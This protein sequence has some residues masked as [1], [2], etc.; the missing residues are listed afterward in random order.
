MKAEIEQV[1]Q[2][3]VKCPTCGARTFQVTHLMPDLDHPKRGGSRSFG[4]WYCDACGQGIRGKLYRTGF[5][6]EVDVDV[7]PEKHQDFYDLLKLEPRTEPV[8]FLVEASHG[9]ADEEDLRFL[10]EE[11]QCPT[12]FIRCKLMIADGNPDPHGLYRYVK[13]VPV[14]ESHKQNSSLMSNITTEE[15]EALLGEKLTP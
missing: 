1:I 3:W 6:I 14:P 5:V 13:S 11:H 9:R 12:N 8:Y 2:H 10:Y 15:L 4:P 7:L